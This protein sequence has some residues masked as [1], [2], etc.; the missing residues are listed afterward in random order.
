VYQNLLKSNNNVQY[1]ILNEDPNKNLA[2]YGNKYFVN[3]HNLEYYHFFNNLL[4]FYGGNYEPLP[5]KLDNS[6]GNILRSIQNLYSEPAIDKRYTN[7]VLHTRFN[8]LPI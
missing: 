8:P 7:L 4:E 1:L 3:K 5:L 6:I 2:N